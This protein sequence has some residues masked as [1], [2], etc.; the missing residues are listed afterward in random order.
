MGDN[1]SSGHTIAPSMDF[2]D[3]EGQLARWLEVIGQYDF[4]IIH[5]PGIKHGSTDA[6]SRPSDSKQMT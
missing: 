1:S 6:L 2:K 4:E 5:R 3:P